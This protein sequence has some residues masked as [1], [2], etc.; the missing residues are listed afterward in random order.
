MDY[1][2]LWRISR[3]YVLLNRLAKAR[4]DVESYSLHILERLTR[5]GD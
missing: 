3:T 2:E 5:M 1:E 4:Y